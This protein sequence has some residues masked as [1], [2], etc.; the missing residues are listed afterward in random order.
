MKKV[1]SLSLALLLALCLCVPVLAAGT[2]TVTVING[3]D[4]SVYDTFTVGDGEDFVFNLAGSPPCD[5][6]PIAP[7]D[8]GSGVTATVGTVTYSK[9]TL[10]GP[11]QYPTAETVTVSGITADTVITVTPNPEEVGS[12]FPAFALGE[13]SGGASGEA[14]SGEPSGDSSSDDPSGE[15]YP[16]FQEYKQYLLDTLLLDPF[17]QGNEALLRADLEAA[18][19]PDDENIQHFTG[20]G[21]VDQAPAGV[22]FPMTYDVWYAAN[23]GAS[24]AEPAASG[25]LSKGG[26][27]LSGA[28]DTSMDAFKT[29]LKAYMD[30][31]P[32]ME[33]HEEELYGLI[34]QEI[35]QAPVAMAWENWFEENAMTYDEFVAAGGVYS[36]HPF[37][38]T[39]PAA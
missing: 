12:E 30:C 2:H 4:G 33:G 11:N 20:S 36:L 18:Q 39:S 32:E 28:G 24:S 26:W 5:M 6:G 35:W 22:V 9:V 38:L 1:L 19:T 17:W 25:E 16:L 29:Y 7:G 15:A 13:G 27:P 10:G 31:V 21:D 34:D 3:M 23:G 14:S 8:E 37:Q